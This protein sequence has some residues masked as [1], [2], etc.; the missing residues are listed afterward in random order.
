MGDE[1]GKAESKLETAKNFKALGVA[2]D[3]ISKATGLPV[4][5]I[6]KLK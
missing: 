6:E 4:E 5:I 1:E 2:T 3:I